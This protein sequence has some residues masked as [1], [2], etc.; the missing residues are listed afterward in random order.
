MATG[1]LLDQPQKLREAI[2]SPQRLSFLPTHPPLSSLSRTVA[3]LARC[4]S[5]ARS[6]GV[7]QEYSSFFRSV[8]DQMTRRYPTGVSNQP[9]KNY[10]NALVVS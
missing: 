2:S 9:Q 10:Q 6:V 1:R 4:R 3:P 7:A 8:R 5:G